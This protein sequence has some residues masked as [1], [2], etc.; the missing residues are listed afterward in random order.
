MTLTQDGMG[1]FGSLAQAL[2]ITDGSGANSA[3]FGDPMGTSSNTHGLTTILAD[4]GQRDALIAFVDEAL[5]PP[6][7]HRE[8]EQKWI[9]LFA[10]TS[11]AITV[12]AVVEPV[13][14][15][16]R[17]GVAVEHHAGTGAP[18]VKT[19]IH[20]PIFHVP[21]SGQ[22]DS[23]PTDATLP[24]WL[25]L[26]RPG[27]RITIG[28]EADFAA[29]PPVPGE[30]YLGGATVQLAIPT[31]TS[32]TVG[33]SLSLVDLQLPGA[34]TPQSRTLD[35][36]SLATVGADVLEF[37]VG[38]VRQQI[39]ALNPADPVFR[40]I[41]G[42]AGMLG[43]RGPAVG[44]P[45]LPVAE[46]TTR[47][48]PALV[49]WVESIL[50]DNTTLDAW[51]AELGG[52]VGGTPDAATN[53]VGFAIGP[54]T[55]RLGL[56]VTPGTGGH[57][58]LVP[59]LDVRWSPAP[60]TADLTA[61]VDLLRADTGTGSVTAV[62]GLRAEA[63]FGSQAHSGTALLTGAT[64]VAGLRVGIGLDAARHP[65]FTLT[66]HGVDLPGGIHH[67]L[68]D[69][70]SPQAAVA[71]VDS[72][73]STALST[74]LSA[75][76]GAQA[77][78]ERLLGV[79]A[80]AN[81]TAITASALIA[82]PLAAVRTYWLDVLQTPNAMADVLGRLAELLTG[83]VAAP[84]QTG[85][86]G[87]PWRL[88]LA[89]GVGL[90]A[91]RETDATH[92]TD[93][94]V[95]ALGADAALPVLTG[96]E[97]AVGADVVLLRAE[98][99]AGHLSLASGASAH[100]Q[101][102]PAAAGPMTLDL[103]IATVAFTGIG[104]AASW[105]P[106]AGL[107]A[108]VLGD[109]LTITYT[110]PRTLLQRVHGI[111]L[112]QISA[113]GAVT[114]TP[115]W[116]QV[117]GLVTALLGR[118]RS[119]IL[120]TLL[121]LVGWRG[122]G[123]H[124]RLGAL[125]ADP[126]TAVENWLLDLALDCVNIRT[127]LGP[128][129]LLLSGGGLA[130]PFGGGRPADPYRCP[131]A[132]DPRAP[133]LAVWTVPGCPPVSTSG[134][135]GPGY[136][137]LLGGYTVPDGRAI[138]AAL[139]A[140]GT[141]APDLADLLVGR[142]RL[143]EGI[144]SLVTRWKDTDGIV[145]AVAP[146]GVTT[147]VLTGL[148]Y[149]ELVANGRTGSYV[150]DGLGVAT[151]TVVHVGCAA[152][153]LTGVPGGQAIDATTTTPTAMPAATTGQWFVQLPTPASVA[154][155]RSDHDT[156]AALAARLSLVLAGRSAD[157]VLVGYGPAGAAAVR[158][159]VGQ[160][161]VTAVV[162][163]G[164]PWSAV[165]LTSLTTGLGGDALRLLDRLVP[166]PLPVW[167]DTLLALGCD[168]QR[169]GQG[170]VRRAMTVLTPEDLPSAAAEVLPSTAEVHAVFGA[171]PEADVRSAIAAVAA[172]GI[173][174][175]TAAAAAEVARTTGPPTEVHVGVDLPVLD[176][177]L[178]GLLVGV[179]AR[180]DLASARRATPHLQSLREVV[181]DV[182]LGVTDGWL[183][184][185]PGA[186][187]QDLAVRWVEAR[188]TIPLGGVGDGA[189]EIVLH[190]ARAFAAYRESWVVRADG[191]G[192]T[193]TTALP[194]VKILLSEIG[195]RIR[196]AS[197]A[198]ADLLTHLGI[199]RDTGVDPDAIDH[200]LHDPVT[201]IRPLVVARAA[202]LADDLRTL[203]GVTVRP[204]DLA[205][206]AIRIG[207]S[208]LHVDVDL[209]V[210]TVTGDVTLA[211][212][213]LPPLE[214]TLA[215]GP[216]GV[217]ATAALGALVDGLGG[218]RLVG[219]AGTS[220]AHL[221]IE[222]RAAGATS[223]TT[224][225]LYPA[226][227]T[228][229]LTRLATVAVPAVLAQQLARWCRTEAR[230]AGRA[231][232]DAGLLALGLLGPPG[233]SGVQ[234]V[235]LPFGLFTDPGAWL[236]TRSDPL[237]AAV[238][239]LEA[240][241]PVVVPGRAVGATGW[242]LDNGLTIAYAVSAGR[243]D[244]SAELALTPD[245]AGKAVTVAVTGG[246]SITAAGAVAPLLDA[247]VLIDGPG[248][249]LQV[250]PT[251]TLDFVRTA[252]GTPIRLYP[253]GAGLA[254]AIGAAAESAVRVAL[255]EVVGHRNDGSATPL[256][257]VARALHE[258][259]SGLDLLVADQFTDARIAAFISPSPAAY[260]EGHLAGVV[261]AGVQALA[262]AL[263]PT[264]ALV[265]VDPVAGG[266]RR[267]TFGTVT[268]IH[269]DL[270]ATTPSLTIGGDVAL[271]DRDANLI[272]H[273]ALEGLTLSPLGVRVDVRAGPFV[274]PAGPVVLRPIAVI[275]AGFTG[276]GFTPLVGV[277][278]GLD[279][280]GAQSV[281]VRFGAS[282]V[283]VAAVTRT[284]GVESGVDVTPAG[285][286]PRVLGVALD[287]ASS[288]LT[289]Q[290]GTVVTDRATG[291]LQGVVFT[292]GGRQIDTTL[293]GDFEHPERLLHRLEVLLW[294]C[295]T[296][297]GHG[298]NPVRPLGVTIAGAVKISLAS[299]PLGGGQTQV[300]LNVT[301][302]GDFAFPT[303]GVNVV[304]RADASWIDA[305]VQPGLS[306]FI[307]KGT[308]V[309]DLVISPAFTV[310]GLGVRIT[311]P[312]GPLLEL[313]SIALDGIGLSIYAEV[314]PVGV[315]GGAQIELVGLA[316]APG[317]GGDNGVA[318]KIM[319]DVG[320]SSKNNRPNFSP[321]LSVQRQPGPGQQIKIG[322]R[323]GEPPGPWWLVIQRQLGP[324]YVDRIGLGVVESGG[325]VTEISLLFSGQLSVFGLTAAVDRLSI[326]WHGGDVLSISSWSVDLMGLAVSADF[327]GLSLSGGLLKTVDGDST[328]Y[329]GMLMGRFA[330]YGLSVFGGYS[331]DGHGH[332]SFFIFGA[333]NGPIGGPPAFFL[334]G[335]GGGLG[336]NRGLVI[337][338]DISH[339]GDFPFIQALD[340]A[341]KP[342]ANP[343]DEL[344]ALSIY[345]PHQM[346][347]FWFA[348]G[349]SFTC[350][351]LIDG[352]AVVAV[353]FGN[354][355]TIDLLGLARMALPRPQAAIVSIE[356]A[357]LVHFSTSEGVF[358]MKAQLTD[359]S[360]LLYRDVRLTGGFAFALWWKGP[361]SGQFVVTMGGYH[362]SF[363]RDGYPVVPRLGIV[364]QI[365]SV[366]V[367]KGE[368]YFALT[369]EAL[370]AGTKVVVSLDL[371]WVWARV[372]FG[373]DGIV[374]FDPFWFEVSAYARISAGIHIDL[375]WFGTI[376]FSITLGASITVWG[377]DFAGRAEFEIG[378]C[379]VPIE[380][381][382]SKAL[383]PPMPWPAFVAKYL[384]ASGSSARTLS[385]ITGKGTLP[386]AAG[387]QSGAPSSDGTPALPFRVFAEFELT[388]TTS[389]PATAFA[390]GATTIPVPIVRAGQATALGLSPMQAHDLTSTVAV[391]LFAI[392][393][394]T[395]AA[396][397][398][399]RLSKLVTDFDTSPTGPRSGTDS[400]PIGVWGP[401]GADVPSKPLP[402][403][404]VVQAGKLVVLVAGIEG[405]AVGPQID[406]RQVKARP[407]DRR[408]LPLTAKGTDRQKFLNVAKALDDAPVKAITSASDALA[409]AAARLF[410]ERNG[411]PRGGH[412][413]VARAAYRLDHSAPP[414]FGTLT[415]GLAP[416]NADNGVRTQLDPVTAPAPRDPRSPFV[417]GLLTSGVGAV[418]RPGRTTVADGRLKRRPAP[419]I[420]SVHGRMALH[421][422]VSL[423]LGAPPSV[424]SAGTVLAS[425]SV[426]RTDAVGSTR[427]YAGGP[428]GTPGLQSLV[429]GLRTQAPRASARGRR[430]AAAARA[431]AAATLLRSG[432]VVALQCPDAAFD[433]DEGRRPGLTLTGRAR[434]TV[435]RGRSV[436]LDDDVADTTVSIPAGATHV[437]IHA[438][439][440][441]DASDGLAGWHEGTRV[442]RLGSQTALAAG[443]VLSSAATGGTGVLQW[444]TAG[445]VAHAAPEVTTRFTRPVHTVAVALSGT[446]PSTLDPTELHLVGGHV[447]TDQAGVE[448]LPQ[449]VMLGSTSVLVYA[450]VPD[451]DATAMSVVVTAG[452]A[453]VVS[454][455]VG[456]D[457]APE[458]LTGVLAARGL[459]AAT[460]KVLAVAGPGCQV[461]WTAPA[462]PSGGPKR[463]RA[464]RP[465]RARRKAT[466]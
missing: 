327:S 9:P 32:D 387:S 417:A 453:W 270:D 73:V 43:L 380:F 90:R 57:P 304:L 377:P 351:S 326:T 394:V 97:V 268:Q 16:V 93:T 290:L 430:S 139:R 88:D 178:G 274:I 25:L 260:L 91:W 253:A 265:R 358:L 266:V 263:D 257:A 276:T 465:S 250:A 404:D 406:Y 81:V 378:P 325:R 301:P 78:V 150:L 29:A 99:T 6:D 171:V 452:S 61:T 197:P 110:D 140:A 400:Y 373:A 241:A 277:G 244:L 239:V 230:D 164:T 225:T 330:A 415:D 154:A 421:L 105:A 271:H 76:G 424:T 318:N 100:V 160:P 18:S 283:D 128:V 294:N 459:S 334:T 303:S 317:G 306:I 215:A 243:L 385:A 389:A 295:A 226:V 464:A 162:T 288:V 50:D 388:I 463:P 185:G 338:Q 172:A 200:L 24:R 45:A 194:E 108:R 188:V 347:N 308:G 321:A 442:A 217:A 31:T 5:G 27:G 115:D 206:T 71:A 372:E 176:L 211:V 395:G 443:C 353:S 364:W 431:D 357:L 179:G 222:S 56:R 63:V 426:P 145:G 123:A 278:V 104:V 323:A 181:L 300:G 258:L 437:G 369:S 237:A 302:V 413:A 229:A 412:S 410:T 34:T 236:R 361:L 345:F 119:D 132:G 165:A 161:R 95:L 41:M 159:T 7:L 208:G 60:G 446:A 17:V 59:W 190:E 285:V 101:L 462:P 273:V 221:A 64:A 49:A 183:V 232:I 198:L 70:S 84:T 455:V 89:S 320:S 157:V 333:I 362:P 85:A 348:A 82:D 252:P 14:G 344:H 126:G 439:G 39:D 195:T 203:T 86:V 189:T 227:D 138:A 307:L 177:D 20:V 460:A 186:A 131:I 450:V 297:P 66:L 77:A 447:A 42:L 371:G 58:T 313:G 428:L 298:V 153:W 407:E 280:D 68:L 403:G 366:L 26:G 103:E 96:L 296:D 254:D 314:N 134:P 210:G 8:G 355:L 170:L 55:L 193:A 233:P 202:Q 356:L 116:D 98:L 445:S 201:T 416:A 106:T 449:V 342:P 46:L 328:S 48:L 62:P 291:M 396:T 212:E 383:P 336:I 11:P 454:G 111:P 282:G 324:L 28:V 402:Q 309:G 182:H 305:T 113:S 146:T 286:A 220:G 80:P 30:A 4:T 67:D 147:S 12:Y 340:P 238:A 10:E 144:D 199:L 102:R 399:A 38:M 166:D 79:T 247:E 310:A 53:S 420:E 3:W 142:T 127:A 448:R 125:I 151:D 249:R 365:S 223:S 392:D 74:A 141:S 312:A 370:M 354:G 382:G 269:L 155:E 397:P 279:A 289:Q 117:E 441:A 124:L 419:T 418:I 148:S 156:V 169:R 87:D 368:S 158:A 429:G 390:F 405:S 173:A 135:G 118:A 262:D 218:I 44:V 359:N 209:A 255:N 267:I 109:G 322:L 349:I 367:I 386:T 133:G 456:S 114:F 331:D 411:L 136:G 374:Y 54:A 36:E 434:V 393:P 251:V 168:P 293:F 180:V 167:T 129:A 432:D 341:A 204:S 23:R 315:G 433:V 143:G 196:T 299:E 408:P 272:G 75:L 281:E 174:A 458:E 22:T 228:D 381:G 414:M 1:A 130:T 264:H 92:G 401:P 352:V 149:A 184:G 451:Q 256:R 192:V 207:T 438:D 376:S 191:D 311:K 246:L 216:T 137:E 461:S 409:L 47:G 398:D 112:P 335:L 343:M 35:L 316:V 329:V 292:G 219:S 261:T 69:L 21:R 65:A 224:T 435:L 319:N 275:R 375:G 422:P 152:D 235:V 423:T 94:L 231:T 242:P 15:A 240:L 187:Q 245:V 2:G 360:W 440:D 37:V 427:S 107:A 466:P 391:Q 33:F 332:A 339:F 51:L 436:L 214:L 205:P 259:G 121:D 425:G 122:S 346:G 163:V 13:Q 40:H 337:P 175:R 213:G 363:H 457:L 287:L 284:A 19:T 234:D 248:L 384:E 350:F 72:V 444:D 52:L 83:T 379:T 120:A